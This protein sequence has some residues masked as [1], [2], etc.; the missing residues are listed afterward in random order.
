[1]HSG[2]ARA[3]R[4]TRLSDFKGDLLAKGHATSESSP[5]L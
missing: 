3:F 2:L 5:V 1:M 4:I